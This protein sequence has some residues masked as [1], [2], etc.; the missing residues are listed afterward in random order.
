MGKTG[1]GASRRRRA[2]GWFVGAVSLVGL[3]AS[4]AVACIGDC[5]GRGQVTVDELIKGVNIGLGD[6]PLEQC[7]YF[8][9]DL[10]NEVTVD[11]LLTGIDAALNGCPEPTILTLAGTGIAGMNGDGKDGPETQLY[12]VQDA[13]VGP[14]GLIYF[15]DWNNHRIR[16]I[17][18]GVVE[19]IAGTGELGD[20]KDGDALYVQ[21]NHPTNVNFDSQGRLLIA[22][23]HNSLVKRMDF[24][25]GL[26]ENLAGTGA[27]AFGGDG[28]PGNSAALDLP[29]SVVEDSKGDLIISDQGNFRLRLLNQQGI[30]STIAG[31]GIKGYAGDGGPAVSA[32]MNTPKGQSAPPAGRIVLDKDDRIY[33]ADTGNH[34]IRL[35]DTD[36]TIRTI[37][38]SGVA[39]YEG[40]GGPATAAQ[41][42][43]PSDVA[44]SPNG[45]L[46]IA[47]T[48]NSVIRAVSPDGIITT[49][50]GIGVRGFAGEGTAAIEAKLDRPYGVEVAHNGDIYIADTHNHRIRRVSDSN[51]GPPPTPAPTPTPEPIIPCSGEVGSICTWAG[52]GGT[53]LNGDGH[54]RL[55]SLLYWPIDIE[56]LPDGRRILLD[57]NNHQIREVLSDETLKTVVGSDFVGDGPV[58]LS[59]L[60]PEGADPLTVDLNHPTD[61][62]QFSNGDVL[63]MAWHN[64]KLRMIDHQTERVRVIM[65]A[66]PGY[67]GDGGPAKSAL[68]NQ[69]PHGVLDPAG[70]LFIIDQR[71]QRIRVLYDFDQQRGDAIIN[72]VVGTGARGYNGD[73]LAL[74]TQV[75]FPTGPNPEPSGGLALDSQG[76]LYFSD[77]NNHRIRRVQFLN[78]DFTSGLVTTIAGTGA[79]GFSGDGGPAN[80]AQINYPEDMEIGPDGN[81]YFADTN[82]DRVRRIDLTTG[83]IDTVAGNGTRAYSG[84]G[85]PAT[86][87]SLHRPFG[88]AFDADGDLYVSDTF[89]S[90]IRKVER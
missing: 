78:S 88:I 58:D 44:L 5:D 12:L 10:S 23:W 38:G 53:G 51:N 86:E 7:S 1:G 66:A 74:E 72:T 35:I 22:A 9:R 29:S 70:N 64:H 13:T 82:N 8:D 26:V 16:R 28:G 45:I 81:L 69:P 87:A 15:P 68:L 31:S 67:S 59:D 79:P 43:T 48:M 60:T 75:S 62:Q 46:Y 47:D 61:L 90:R 77:T 73:G 80:L 2:N 11:E 39:G 84:D 34:V 63:I 6:Q 54:D 83:V 65:G 85:G 19:T 25:T 56:F 3:A 57:W 49:V 52:T 42:N 37:A 27:R 17:V 21:F 50:A 30:I 4:P 33:V 36:G 14:D 41:L 76:N 32:Q 24:S 89:N 55:A 20:A 71:N 40:D 18:D